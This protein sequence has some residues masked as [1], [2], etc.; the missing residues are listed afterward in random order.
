MGDS[1]VDQLKEIIKGLGT[2]AEHEVKDMNKDFDMK[3]HKRLPL[4]KKTPWSQVNTFSYSFS[5][6]KSHF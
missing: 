1:Q 2:P 5:K 6:P 3:E 4:I